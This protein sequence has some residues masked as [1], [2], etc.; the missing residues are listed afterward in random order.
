MRPLIRSVAD[1]AASILSRLSADFCY[2]LS[3]E[4]QIL[5]RM[6][7]EYLSFSHLDKRQPLSAARIPLPYSSRYR[8]NPPQNRRRASRVYLP[9][10][11]LNHL[12][13]YIKYHSAELPVFVHCL[14]RD[15]NVAM[16]CN[17]CITGQAPCYVSYFPA[18][19]S[20]AVRC[21]T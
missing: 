16:C 14:P 10:K 3:A 21:P 12:L 8:P 13:S 4:W 15:A 19:I 5:L 9:S 11:Y 6:N 20:A 17:G 18:L 2:I 1:T 7:V